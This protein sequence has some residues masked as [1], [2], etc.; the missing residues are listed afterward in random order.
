MARVPVEDLP[1]NL[2]PSSDLPL[3]LPTINVVPEDDLPSSILKKQRSMTEKLGRGLS[4]IARGAAVPVTGAIAG[5]ALAGPVGA[6]AGGLALPAAELLTKSLNLALPDKYDIPSP[7]A[8]VE[9]GLTKLGFPEPETQTERALQVGGSALG[10]VGGQ[11]G[12]LGQLAKTATTPV[13]RGIAQTLSQQPV[14]QVAAALPVGATSQYV[15][16]ETGSPGLGMAAGIAAGIPFAIGASGKLQAPTVQ[17]LKGQA[18]QQYKFA[19]EAGA[20]FKKNPYKQFAEGLESTLIK[21]GMDE[22]L[23]PKVVAA[24]KRINQEKGGNVTL[25]KI[26]I[27]RR[28]GRGAASSIDANESR[29][30]NIIID[31]LDDF[32]EN[33][34]P[35][36]LAKGSSEAVRALVDARELWKRAKKTEIIDELV[37]SAELRAEA[38]YT[39]SGIENALRRKLVNLADNPKKL[40]A[41]SKEEQEL[42]KST[43]KGG[44]V[45]NAL[46]LFGKLAP[47]GVVSG[48]VS[49]G[50]GALIGGT[51]GAVVVPVIGSLARK[52]AE[53]LG[54]RNIEKL[55]NRLALGYEPIPQVSTRGLISARELAAPIINP[56]SGLLNEGQ[57]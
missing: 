27:L 55:R 52:G 34:Q 12:A 38:N 23:T 41:F 21:E 20:I 11:V 46:R 54:L 37:A 19:E 9:K 16:E 13:G 25:E 53:Q 35:S 32:V 14:R 30:G 31:K 24:L 17:E 33:A 40:R 57:E 29:I 48:G 39:Q 36:Q 47:T 6:I 3:E 44:S 43:A 50:G 5:G 49:V 26:E 22:T 2:V 4:S 51:P 18:G 10:G 8:Q 45:Q 7:T 15:A 42:I 1:S 56:I 28:I